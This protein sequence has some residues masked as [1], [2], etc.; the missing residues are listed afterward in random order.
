MPIN[1]CW[2]SLDWQVS[3]TLLQLNVSYCSKLTLNL[4]LTGLSEIEIYETMTEYNGL[5]M[6]VLIEAQNLTV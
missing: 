6:I 5:D 4:C 3:K 2:V 1:T